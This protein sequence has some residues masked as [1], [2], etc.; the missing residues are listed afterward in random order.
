MARTSNNSLFRSPGCFIYGLTLWLA[1]CGTAACSSGSPPQTAPVRQ[2]SYT[3]VKTYPHAAGD[4]TQG[5]VFVDDRLYESTGLYGQSAV[6]IKS[7]DSGRIIKRFPLPERYFGEGLAAVDGRLV[8][9]TY[10]E[11]TG[12]VYDRDTLEVLQEFRYQGEGWGLT[13]DGRNLIMSDGSAKLHFLDPASHRRQRSLKVTRMGEVMG[14]LNELEYVEGRIYANV[15]LRNIIVE[16]DAITGHV[17]GE[18]D[19]SELADRHAVSPDS[20]LNGIAYHSRNGTF[21]VTGKFWPA[22]YE[23]KLHAPD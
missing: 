22:L 5:L 20:V 18:A 19:L 16:I 1:V 12:F 17:T 4:F 3:V 23:I 10:R 8:Q 13:Y 6:S 15:W 11:Q 2:Y 9:L 21:L 7:L 14:S